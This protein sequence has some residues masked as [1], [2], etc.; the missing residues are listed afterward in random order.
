MFSK[1]QLKNAMINVR[2]INDCYISNRRL[3]VWSEDCEVIYFLVQQISHASTCVIGNTLIHG[4]EG[5]NNV[6][7]KAVSLVLKLYMCSKSSVFLRCM[8]T[9]INTGSLTF[10]PYCPSFQAVFRKAMVLHEMG[11]VDESLQVFLQC[12]ALDE[13]FPCAKRQVEKVKDFKRRE[14]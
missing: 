3:N 12:L 8:H 7:G 9:N 6:L 11:Q 14:L 13:D 1:P 5:K 4:M 10:P 2:A